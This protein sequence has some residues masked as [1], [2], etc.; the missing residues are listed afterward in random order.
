MSLA[1][2]RRIATYSAAM[3]RPIACACHRLPPPTSPAVTAAVS[4]LSMSPASL[5]VSFEIA[6]AS[7]CSLARDD[8]LYRVIA[9]Q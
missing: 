3:K 1:V 7:T 9:S 5:I 6:T 2:E 4:P 8:T